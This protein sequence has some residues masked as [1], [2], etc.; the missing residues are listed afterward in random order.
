MSD[1]AE[2]ELHAIEQKWAQA[3]VRGNAD[4]ASR[5]MADDWTVITPDG[6]VLDKATFLEMIRSGILI[7]QEM[8]F[9]EVIVRVYSVQ[10]T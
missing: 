5:Y 8:E 4:A 2:A 7:H 9:T 3:F 6:N 1:S 10:R